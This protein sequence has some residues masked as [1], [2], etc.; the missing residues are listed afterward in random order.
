[1]SVSVGFQVLTQRAT[2][3][4]EAF[5]L[6]GWCNTVGSI[7][8]VHASRQVFSKDFVGFLVYTDVGLDS[9]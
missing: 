2:N 7:R 8:L 5:S 6:R 1:M 4:R 3:T 9:Y